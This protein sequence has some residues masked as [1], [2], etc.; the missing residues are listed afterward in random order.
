MKLIVF[1]KDRPFQLYTALE[2]IEKHISG[3][4]ELIVQYDFSKEKFYQGY[5]KLKKEF[6]NIKFVDESTLGFAQTLH[7]LLQEDKN[8]NVAFEV[9]DSIYYKDI[10]L[11]IGEVALSNHLNASKYHFGFDPSLFDESIFIK[12][13]GHNYL[14][15]DR[16]KDY[17]TDNLNLILRYPFN[18]SA[19]IHRKKDVL[20]LFHR[21]L[22][23]HPV[24]L[25]V[26][27]SSDII[28]N[29]YPYNLYHNE[30]VMKQIHFNNSL[31]RYDQVIN[32]DELNE[33]LENG[34]VLDITK[35]NIDE[36]E[37]DM[38]WFDGEDIGRFP[39]FPWEIA[40]KYHSKLIE[41]R[42]RINE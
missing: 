26:R 10:D 31:D 34:E 2:S 37:D 24:D 30:E 15:I 17:G 39:I 1:S 3:Y 5:E 21:G 6:K 20:S 7:L 27:G 16:A 33:Y 36:Y 11:Q 41:N 29:R 38:R 19:C 40:P 9:D 23:K 12:T 42:R 4:E 22:P 32:I 13:K 28:F 8:D 25:E 14:G 35:I 18:V